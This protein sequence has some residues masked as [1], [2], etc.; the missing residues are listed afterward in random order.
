[1]RTDHFLDPPADY[2]PVAMWFL[3][4]SIDDE[5]AR[6]QIRA[7]ASG[8][9][10]AVQVAARTGLRTP[11]YLSQ[12]WFELIALVLDEALSHGLRVWLADEY[13]YPSGTSGGEVILRHPQYR[14]WQMRA[15]RPPTTFIRSIQ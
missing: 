1:M 8:G 15:T 11:P 9:L 6:R 4:A 13:P 3:N 5:E 7:M 14:A 2:R 12:R 10:G